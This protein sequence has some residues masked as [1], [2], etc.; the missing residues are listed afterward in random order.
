LVT[1][2]IY[3]VR[4][5]RGM[6]P[7]A[8]NRYEHHRFPGEIIGHSIWLYFRFYLSSRGVE[9]LLCGRGKD[10]STISESLCRSP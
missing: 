6:T 2:E 5:T 8:T 10:G 9:E 3:E 4:C 7:L 1:V